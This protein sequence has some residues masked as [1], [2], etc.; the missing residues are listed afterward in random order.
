MIMVI[1]PESTAACSEPPEVLLQ[2][3]LISAGKKGNGKTL[4]APKG[5]RQS[6]FFQPQIEHL[7]IF[8]KMSEVLL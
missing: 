5:N 8:R 3:C 7:L 4:T 6:D 1:T 2:T